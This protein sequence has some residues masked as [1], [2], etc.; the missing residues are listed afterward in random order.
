MS[1]GER[2]F[3]GKKSVSSLIFRHAKKSAG[4]GEQLSQ[5]IKLVTEGNITV[6]CSLEK[7]QKLWTEY[8]L[9]QE[10]I[11]LC[12]NVVGFDKSVLVL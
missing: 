7:L 9:A 12:E 4:F 11:R 8:D 6:P 3:L 2:Y 5:A 1:S 10:V